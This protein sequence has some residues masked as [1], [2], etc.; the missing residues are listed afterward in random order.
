MNRGAPRS[1]VPAHR[2]NG[3]RELGQEVGVV[4][5]RVEGDLPRT[6]AG[7][8]L[9]V[10]VRVLEE[11]VRRVERVEGERVGTQIGDDDEPGERA[12][13]RHVRVRTGL[14]LLVHAAP[15]APDDRNGAVERTVLLDAV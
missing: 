13:D 10:E 3:R 8:D 14:A 5:V 11:A 15:V 2:A 6:G 9:R 7:L 1:G 4:A 12:L